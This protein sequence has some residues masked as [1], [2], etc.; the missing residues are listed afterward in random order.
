MVFVAF[1]GR[2]SS[3][4]ARTHRTCS[5]AGIRARVSQ[6]SS[7]AISALAWHCSREYR[8][9]RSRLPGASSHTNP[10][11][12]F[13]PRSL[14]TV[15]LYMGSPSLF[16]SVSLFFSL[17]PSFP[18]FV[19]LRSLL[20]VRRGVFLCFLRFSPFP[21]SSSLR[22]F[23]PSSSQARLHFCAYS[24][25]VIFDS[26]ILIDYCASTLHFR[27]PFGRALESS[28]FRTIFSCCLRVSMRSRSDVGTR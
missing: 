4:H 12:R 22:L 23:I 20:T 6:V 28:R 10:S 11:P 15:F 5:L 26:I 18:P 19:C 17:S 9:E 8:G 24:L 25:R 7:R 2:F 1:R 16:L 27:T 3:T 14:T 13:G 21:A